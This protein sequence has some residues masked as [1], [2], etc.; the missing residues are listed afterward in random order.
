[1]RRRVNIVPSCMA[2]AMLALAVMCAA[3][4]CKRTTT[5]F[6]SFYSFGEQGWVKGSPLYF[7]PENLDSSALYDLGLAVRYN[8]DFSYCDLA[9][10]VDVID[11]LMQIQHHNIT[12]ELAD[13]YGNWKGAGFGEFYQC[14]TTVAKKMPLWKLHRI[15]VW[16]SLGVDTVDGVCDVG[17]VVTRSK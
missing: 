3:V 17:I 11:T 12:L 4:S 14:N 9:V 6:S 10:T 2:C 13:D 7:E 15:A 1:M 8:T 5:N 16:Q